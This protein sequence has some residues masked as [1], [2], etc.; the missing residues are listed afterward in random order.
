MFF[1]ILKVMILGVTTFVLTLELSK[2]T[3]V[4]AA[5]TVVPVPLIS[6]VKKAIDVSGTR[7]SEAE[8]LLIA[9]MLTQ[10]AEQTFSDRGHQEYWISLIGVESAYDQRLKSPVGATGLGQ[11]MPK[12]YK[13]LAASCGIEGL[14]DDTINDRFINAT[15]SACH[16]KHLIEESNGVISLALVGYN[17]GLYSPSFKRANA[18]GVPVEET[19]GY[20]T[21]I[22]IAKEKTK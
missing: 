10:I 2:D 16:F 21:K 19:A 6:H 17:A 11:L 14:S 20:V 9:Q 18:G 5:P 15:I 3:P 4:E 22:Q 8:K 13:D 7:I 1:K 12:F